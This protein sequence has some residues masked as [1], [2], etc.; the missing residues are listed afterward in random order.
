MIDLSR[1]SNVPLIESM[2]QFLKPAWAHW[3]LPCGTCSRAREKPLSR[4]LKAAGAPE[5]RPLRNAEHLMG[6]PGLTSS[7]KSRVDSA[8]DIYKLAIPILMI[9]C[10]LHC[11]VSL[12]NPPRSWL[13][14]VLAMLIKEMCSDPEDPFRLWFFELENV[15]FDMCEHGGNRPK[16]TRL[17]ATPKVFSHL[18]KLCSGTHQHLPW[19]VSKVEGAW[20]FSTASEAEY[21]KVLAH[22]MVEAVTR[23]INP[24]LLNHSYK[25]LRLDVLYSV[26]KQTKRHM[27][28]IPEFHHVEQLLAQPT[29]RAAKLLHDFDLHEPGEEEQGRVNNADKKQKTL[30]KFGI[31]FSPEQHI[32]KALTLPHPAS[33]NLIVPDVLRRNLFNILT[34]GLG[35]VAKQRANFLKYLTDLK[36]NFMAEERNLR[37]KMSASV[38]SVTK[39]KALVLWRELLKEA[40]FEDWEIVA[41]HMEQGVDLVGLEVESKLYAKKLQPPLMTPEQ[42]LGQSVWQRKAMISRPITEEEVEQA[43]LL[44]EECVKELE[45]GFLQGPF[46]TESE[47]SQYLGGDAWVLTKRFALLQG[48]EQKAR[49]IDNCKESRINEAFGS[50]S[51]LALHDTDY[52]GG[53]LKFVTTVLSNRERVVI[54]LLSGEVL[55]GSWHSDFDQQPRL[56][57]RCVDLSKAYKQIAVSDDTLKFAVL[58]HRTKDGGWKFYVSKSLPFGASASVYA[59]NKVSRGLWHLLCHKLQLLSTVFFDDFPVFEFEPL[60]ELTTKMITAF[61]DLLG[62]LHATVGKKASPFTSEMTALGVKFNTVDIWKG[63]VVISNKPERMTRLAGMISTVVDNK[64]ASKSDCASIHGMLN[65]ACGFVLAK[66]LK[67]ACQSFSDMAFNRY[68]QSQLAEACKVSLFLLGSVQPIFLTPMNHDCEIVLYTDGAFENSVGTWGVTA[69]DVTA[70]S[71]EIFWGTVPQLLID[72]WMKHAGTQVICEVEMYAHICYRWVKRSYLHRKLGISF[73]DN[74]SCRFSLIKGSSPSPCMRPLINMVSIIESVC[75]FHAWHERVPSASN[76]ADLPSR[77]QWLEASHR[78][79]GCP[80]GDISLPQCALNFMTSL[81][82]SKKL[83]EELRCEIQSPELPPGTF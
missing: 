49:I 60:Q 65:F 18:A 30:K 12:E 77:G 73:I 3:G 46:H 45:L 80:L 66:A 38:S 20:T 69:W 15:D 63:V 75:P 1:E 26:G 58:G 62:W 10:K 82:F 23:V 53:F 70:G 72:F 22:R 61:F 37:G 51:H 11:I 79:G 9:A 81:S 33:A 13:W 71:V 59:F 39:E 64:S 83:A 52:I 76:P 7:E 21:P 2:M 17:K 29:D 57:G 24:E 16:A 42:L 5:P 4:T 19:T 35:T 8:N 54:P 55:T 14:S 27:Q 44:N 78:F 36:K 34:T 41:H 40:K 68:S 25:A 67:P 28:L 43:D 50:S 6:L 31:Y 74:E 56:L 47:V 32:E 48:E